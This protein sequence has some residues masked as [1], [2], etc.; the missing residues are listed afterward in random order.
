MDDGKLDALGQT[1]VSALP[2]AASAHVVAFNQSQ[3]P[4]FAALHQQM[5]AGNQGDATGAEINV[6][7]F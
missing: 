5:S 3:A 7:L 2:G 4:L 6:V 1:I